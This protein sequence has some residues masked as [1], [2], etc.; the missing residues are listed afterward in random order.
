MGSRY[1]GVP[2]RSCACLADNFIHLEDETE[3]CTVGEFVDRLLRGKLPLEK[4][5]GD[6]TGKEKYF[7]LGMSLEDVRNPGTGARMSVFLKRTSPPIT[8]R[9]I[10]R[11]N[12]VGAASVHIAEIPLTHG[13]L[14]GTA[15]AFGQSTMKDSDVLLVVTA[16][17]SGEGKGVSTLSWAGLLSGARG[18]S[19]D[20][21]P[22]NHTFFLSAIDRY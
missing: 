22:W 12:V 15:F 18:S 4:P 5:L 14:A 2:R 8:L 13:E 16:D 1:R 20:A 21:L 3:L 7:D 9:R 17:D 6:A 19:A 10:T 11:V